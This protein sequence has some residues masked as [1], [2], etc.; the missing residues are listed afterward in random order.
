M[1]YK[2]AHENGFYHEWCKDTDETVCD[3]IDKFFGGWPEQAGVL[4]FY[5]GDKDKG[6]TMKFFKSG[7]NSEW[8]TVV[9]RKRDYYKNKL[10]KISWENIA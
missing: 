7:S 3:K 4:M 8:W 10:N 1:S 5:H 6:R 9:M 2:Y